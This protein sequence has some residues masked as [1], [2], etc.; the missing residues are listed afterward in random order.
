MTCHSVEAAP[1]KPARPRRVR[2]AR[3]SL[4]DALPPPILALLAA[5]ESWR[6]LVVPAR[7][8]F[9][10][11]CR[12]FARAALDAWHFPELIESTELCVSELATNAM[13]YGDGEFIGLS[14]TLSNDCLL[15]EVFDQ[16][17]GEPFVNFPAANDEYGR[18]MALVLALS[19]TWGVH[20]FRTF[21]EAEPCW[22]RVWCSF[23][24]PT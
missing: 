20:T 21:G 17:V 22:K 23:T 24:L 13:C 6:G 14:L 5:Q 16:G 7:P 15:L 8:I 4:P 12:A 10:R 1:T 11:E 9:V 2:V 19:D 3:Q 18:G